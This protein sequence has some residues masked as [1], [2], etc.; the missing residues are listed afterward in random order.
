MQDASCAIPSEG[1]VKPDPEWVSHVEE[2][3]GWVMSGENDV[4]QFWFLAGGGRNGKGLLMD[5]QRKLMGDLAWKF[6][7]GALDW[8]PS[9][10]SGHA[11]AIA[12]SEGAHMAF[13]D[14]T[15]KRVDVS[16][17]KAVTGDGTIRASRKHM[18][19]REFR[20]PKLVL[21]DNEV[22]RFDGSPA[23]ADR[24]VATPFDMWFGNLDQPGVTK[25]SR[26]RGGILREITPE[27]SHLAYIR[28]VLYARVR[29]LGRERNAPGGALWTGCARVEDKSRSMLVGGDEVLHQLLTDHM[30]YAEGYREH[31]ATLYKAYTALAEQI[32]R[33][34]RSG[35]AGFTQ[36]LRDV[37]GFLGHQVGAAPSGWRENGRLLR[38]V[39]GCRLNES[40]RSLAGLDGRQVEIGHHSELYKSVSLLCPF[41]PIL[42]GFDGEGW[43]QGEGEAFLPERGASNSYDE[44]RVRIRQA[45]GVRPGAIRVL[46]C[47]RTCAGSSRRDQLFRQGD[48]SGSPR[49]APL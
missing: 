25:L 15:G 21:A 38:G 44:I 45:K 9:G 33:R 36:A 18:G 17:L 6:S 12:E 35:G 24:L 3:F 32:G 40:G 49:R 16:L 1:E 29:I 34:P 13:A 47:A 37:A 30:E 48:S 20:A 46:V 7:K 8:S 27:L 4:Q 11:N 22:P 31:T 14:E 5:I 19:E 39:T 28:L 26:D 41:S 42:M 43:R 2:R 23:V 10:S